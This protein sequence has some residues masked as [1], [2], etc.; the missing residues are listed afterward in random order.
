M[1][2]VL[3][4]SRNTIVEL[5]FKERAFPALPNR[6]NL[7]A[8][9]FSSGR[10][11][12]PPSPVL[13]ICLRNARARPTKIFRAITFLKNVSIHTSELYTLVQFR[14]SVANI[15]VST[16]FFLVWFFIKGKL[17]VQSLVP[18]LSLNNLLPLTTF[19]CCLLKS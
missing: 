15:R 16:C 2:F 14:L 5:V 6:Q 4:V 17:P 12:H 19:F 18:S 3:L 7:R 8:V 11:L 1:C 9:I 10:L 13:P